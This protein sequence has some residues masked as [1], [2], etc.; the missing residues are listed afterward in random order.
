MRGNWLFALYRAGSC[1][2]GVQVD[3]DVLVPGGMSELMSPRAVRRAT[4]TFVE[5]EFFTKIGVPG[6]LG[7]G[8]GRPG[9]CA[10]K[11]NDGCSVSVCA[12]SCRAADP[13][14]SLARA[15][16]VK[17]LLRDRLFLA[18]YG[19][20]RDHRRLDRSHQFCAARKLRDHLTRRHNRHSADRFVRGSRPAS[21]CPR[22]GGL[23]LGE[24]FQLHGSRRH[25]PPRTGKSRKLLSSEIGCGPR[26]REA[27]TAI[28]GG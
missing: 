21:D 24:M 25:S 13:H 9:D 22:H 3:S 15:R 10:G 4:R 5:R 8:R 12:P 16:I 1:S 18:D 26:V 14:Q 6:T 23:A 19:R 2:H 27:P 7:S 20:P 11:A 28:T 17:D